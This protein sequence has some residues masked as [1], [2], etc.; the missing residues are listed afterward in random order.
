ME[1]EPES[2]LNLLETHV[3]TFAEVSQVSVAPRIKFPSIDDKISTNSVY[4]YH[5]TTATRRRR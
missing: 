4:T 5:S 3:G 2:V 1:G